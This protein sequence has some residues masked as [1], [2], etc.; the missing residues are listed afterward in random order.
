MAD[1]EILLNFLGKNNLAIF[2]IAWGE[3]Q[4]RNIDYKFDTKDFYGITEFS[5]FAYLD[6]GQIKG[7]PQKISFSK[8]F[9]KLIITIYNCYIF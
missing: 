7:Y 9:F 5:E 8:L 4:V 6:N 2:W 1:K 3:K